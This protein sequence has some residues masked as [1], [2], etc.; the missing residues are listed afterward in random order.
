MSRLTFLRSCLR[1][2]LRPSLP[3]AAAALLALAAAGSGCGD[4]TAAPA[5]DAGALDAAT[6]D[7]QPADSALP[8]ASGAG[9]NAFVGDWLVTGGQAQ[10]TMCTGLPDLPAQPLAGKM[11]TVKAG[12]LAAIELTLAGCTFQLDVS[13]NVATARPGQSCMTV[14]MLENTTFQVMLTFDSSTFTVSGESGTLVQTGHASANNPLVVMCAYTANAT[15]MKVVPNDGG[16]SAT[17]ALPDGPGAADAGDAADTAR[18]DAAPGDA[19]PA[20]GG[21]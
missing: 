20:D 12:N 21:S 1:P 15:G 11:V 4:D 18:A 3:L 10:A 13:G 19:V 17:D 7:G 5:V 2:S 8:D 16:V 9:I 6:A 14:L